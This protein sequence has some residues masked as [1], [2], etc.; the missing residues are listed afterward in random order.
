MSVQPTQFYLQQL[1]V[2]L[3]MTINETGANQTN[4]RNNA[5]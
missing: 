3:R 1:I 4:Q 2:T 5:K